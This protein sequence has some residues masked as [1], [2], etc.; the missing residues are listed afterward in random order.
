MAINGSIQVNEH[1]AYAAYTPQE[2]V[3]N[4]FAKEAGCLLVKNIAFKGMGWD[5]TNWIASADNRGLSYFHQGNSDFP[6][7]EGLLLSTG[8][9]SEA[10][11]PNNSQ[12]AMSSDG[13]NGVSVAGDTDLNGL[14]AGTG[15]SVTSGAILEFDFVPTT[16]IMEF[17]YIFASEEYSEYVYAPSNT[18]SIFNDVFGFFVNKV[19][20]PTTNI[21]TLPSTTT[22][23]S[24]VSIFNVN[25]GYKTTHA[26]TAPGDS[27]RNSEYFITNL[28]GSVTTQFDGYTVVLTARYTNLEPCETYHL[29]LAIANAGD[30]VLGSG[31]FLQAQ[32]FDAGANFEQHGNGIEG[33]TNI[34]E[35]CSNNKLVFTRTNSATAQ[36]IEFSFTGTA[37][38]GVDFIK[39]GGGA[40]PTSVVFPVGETT[41]EVP[42]QAV[43]D[44][45]ADNGEWFKVTLYCPCIGMNISAE[46]TIYIYE[47]ATIQSTTTTPACFGNSNGTIT[48]TATGGSGTYEY[49]VDSGAWTSSDTFTGL[50]PGTYTV[51]MRDVGSCDIKTTSVVVGNVA[52]IDLQVTGGSICT[53]TKATLTASST[54]FPSPIFQ[55]YSNAALTNLV[56]TGSTF[57]T[58]TTLT[59]N[60]TYYVQVSSANSPCTHSIAVPVTVNAV[61]SANPIAAQNYCH[62]N[63]TSLTNLTGS[64]GA[65]FSWTNDQPSIGLAASGTSNHIPSFTATNTGSV[66]IVAT[67]TVT[68]V[69]NDCSGVPITYTITVNPQ[70]PL[71]VVTPNGPTTFCAGGSVQL[72]A[73]TAAFYQWYRNGLPIPTNS[74]SSTYTVTSL[75]TDTYS[76]ATYSVKV[77]NSYGCESDFST[78]TPIT[79]HPLPTASMAVAPGAICLGSAKVITITLTGTAP[80]N[81]SY[82]DGSNTVVESGILLSPYTIHVTP[83]TAGVTTYS[84]LTITDANGCSQSGNSSVQVTAH[85]IATIPLDRISS[86]TVCPEANAIIKIS[87]PINGASYYVYSDAGG[88]NLLDSQTATG[89][90]ILLNAG[91]V[92]QTTTFYLKITS[93]TDCQENSLVPFEV[94]VRPTL[95]NYP[96]IRLQICPYPAR[97][98]HLSSYLDTTDFKTVNWSVVTS[99]SPTPHTAQGTISTSDLNH[100]THIYSY[101]IANSCYPD[102]NRKVYLLT[103]KDH[104]VGKQADTVV[105]CKDVAGSINLKQILGIAANGTWSCNDPG[106][107]MKPY[108]KVVAPPS[109][110]AGA[111]IL[112]GDRAY[113]DL[114]GTGLMKGYKSDPNAVYLDFVYS[115]PLTPNSCLSNEERRLVVIVTSTLL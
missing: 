73:P 27:P 33:M 43:D 16:T 107:A 56:G 23:R 20:G 40:L 110:L 39:P 68:P 111:M 85:P 72:T 48:I 80:W 102:K 17:K 32:S 100:G 30:D 9:G 109:P 88:V 53:G 51:K 4:I 52:T 46:K 105:V 75:T 106:D 25:N 104:V 22:G 38:N 79:V 61:P 62:G 71:P 92:T 29:K 97:S 47:F 7:A 59:S 83:S 1:T 11:G 35:G 8:S 77:K 37:S 19:G 112:E 60:T 15:T 13:A 2:L 31:V 65:L 98:F 21:A 81:I 57:T 34:F 93:P 78:G 66:P 63:S 64:T 95:A 54:T 67:I 55:W 86:D 82:S 36:T 103:V 42:Y 99:G 108:V 96:D 91:V 90:D 69:I 50:A 70:P 44:G 18:S 10:E 12:S 115:T 94:L 45:I 3:E 114:Q 74:T 49:A 101:N 6:I 113:A 76:T 14:L 26:N 28:D 5:G 24:E 84:I 58:P 89:A 41:V 87:S